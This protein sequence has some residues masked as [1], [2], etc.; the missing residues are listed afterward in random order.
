MD[1]DFDVT[2][3]CFRLDTLPKDYWRLQDLTTSRQVYKRQSLSRRWFATLSIL[4]C[5]IAKTPATA[6]ISG[7]VLFSLS[8]HRSTAKFG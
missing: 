4:V 7:S 2:L 5:S 8:G 3:T 1:A 6:S